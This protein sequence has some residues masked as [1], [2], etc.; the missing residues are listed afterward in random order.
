MRGDIEITVRAT[1]NKKHKEMHSYF[2]TY[3]TVGNVYAQ[4]ANSIYVVVVADKRTIQFDAGESNKK[5]FTATSKTLQLIA[6]T[7]FTKHR[8]VTMFMI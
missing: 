6:Q 1:T 2:I 8:T 4:S 3:N 7:Q 5:H